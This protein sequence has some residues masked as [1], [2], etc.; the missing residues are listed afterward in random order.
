MTRFV[1]THKNG[2]TPYKE[3]TSTS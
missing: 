2:E 1:K 3:D